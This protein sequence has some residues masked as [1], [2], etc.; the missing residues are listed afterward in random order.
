MLEI[1]SVTFT[2]GG[3]N[4]GVYVPVFPT[5][6]ATGMSVH[7]RI[8]AEAPSSY[9][10][11][12]RNIGRRPTLGSEAF[13]QTQRGRCFCTNREPNLPF[14]PARGLVPKTVSHVAILP[15]VRP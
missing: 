13:W 10:A 3:D 7:L 1:A 12:L 9:G 2:N 14:S 5:S 6:G 11:N 4:M 8:S 15:A